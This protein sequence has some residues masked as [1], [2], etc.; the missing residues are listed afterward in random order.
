[1]GAGMDRS[2]GT[3]FRFA[4]IS[5]RDGV[6]VRAGRGVTKET[7]DALVEFRADDVFELA[8]LAV[9]FVVVDAEGILE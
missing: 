6:A 8:R 7:T 9:R 5:R 4:A 1:M 2:A 3:S